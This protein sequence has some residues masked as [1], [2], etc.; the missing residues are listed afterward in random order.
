MRCRPCH[1]RAEASVV[2]VPS[3]LAARPSRVWLHKREG[4]HKEFSP[5]EYQPGEAPAAEHFLSSC[6]L[7][8]PPGI[9][10]LDRRSGVDLVALWLSLPRMACHRLAHDG[11]RP[12][13][14]ALPREWTSLHPHRHP[15]QARGPL[16]AT[17]VHRAHRIQ[18]ILPRLPAVEAPIFPCASATSGTLPRYR[19]ELGTLD[20]ARDAP[21][22]LYPAP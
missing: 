13:G 18:G 6:F 14:I 7:P 19:H 12:P 15:L 1:G 2:P 20:T 3:R 21:I 16:P 22:S 10:A 11:C 8:R 17:Y 9:R 5:H 4:R